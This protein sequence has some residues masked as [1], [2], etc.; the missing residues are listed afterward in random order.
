MDSSEFVFGFIT[1][2]VNGHE[3]DGREF[4]GPGTVISADLVRE[5]LLKRVVIEGKT[6]EVSPAGIRARNIRVS[7]QLNLDG[8][9][10]YHY[11]LLFEEC[12]FAEV[13]SLRNTKLRRLS[14]S[15]STIPGI[16]ARR[17]EVMGE[18]DLR[19]L[20]ESA[21]AASPLSIFPKQKLEMHFNSVAEPKDVLA[22]LT[23]PK[24]WNLS[25]KMRPFTPTLIYPIV[26][27]EWPASV[28]TTC[29]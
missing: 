29:L 7:G 26:S 12:E 4:A 17:I 25:W 22:A 2:C 18:A 1:C 6:Q 20:P 24:W 5:L 23:T 21:R 16:D 3:F 8:F 9:D 27:G 28:R 13:L 19:P 14:L 11:P 15:C 10:L